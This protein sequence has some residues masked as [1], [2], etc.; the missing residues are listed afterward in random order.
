MPTGKTAS[1][2]KPAEE[3]KKCQRCFRKRTKKEA[4]GRGR[5]SLPALEKEKKLQDRRRLV[6]VSKGWGRPG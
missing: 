3:K 6:L 4:V 5:D 1:G 2:L